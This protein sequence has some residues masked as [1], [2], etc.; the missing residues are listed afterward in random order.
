MKQESDDFSSRVGIG[1]VEEVEAVGDHELVPDAVDW[2]CGEVPQGVR[3]EG[4]QDRL[5]LKN[6][7]D[8]AQVEQKN[9]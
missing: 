8:H 2:S 4:P 3:I 6:L 7:E 1:L 5:E 9:S